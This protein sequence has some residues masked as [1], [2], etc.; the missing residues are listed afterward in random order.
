M[1][2][3]NAHHQ[4]GQFLAYHG[5]RAQGFADDFAVWA[6]P[7]DLGPEDR[8]RIRSAAGRKPAA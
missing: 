4:A 6:D 2:H 8:L 1:P 7:K 5:K 3:D